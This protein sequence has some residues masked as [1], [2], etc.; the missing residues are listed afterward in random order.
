MIKPSV[1]GK[2]RSG[3]FAWRGVLRA[4]LLVMGMGM[5]ASVASAVELHGHRGARGLLPENTLASFREA[6]R[7]GVDC[8]E[9][10]VG[11]SRDGQVVIHHDRFLSPV[12]ARR[13]GKW[14]DAP[15]TLRTLS[16][17]ELKQFDVGRIKPGT[18]YAARFAD[19]RPIDGSQIPLLKELLAMP[20]LASHPN[21]CL[22]IE[23]K[24]SPDAPDDTFAPERISQALVEVLDGFK[25]R[26]RARV[27]SFDWRNLRAIAKLAPDL[28]LSFLTAEQ[29]WQDNIQ[30]GKPGASPWLAGIDIDD[31]G[32]SV[33]RA[34]AHFGGRFWSPYFRDLTADALK[35]AHG[36]G[37]KVIVWTV[38]E[39]QD[40]RA[41][42]ELGVDG[43]ITDYP[44][45][46][47]RILEAWNRA[48]TKTRGQ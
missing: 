22:N 40:I 11:L 37:L 3:R 24:T 12:L 41:L 35:E 48:R 34:V 23:I 39:E 7:Q 8:I 21:V 17:A 2:G 26:A 43:V 18:R 36:L 15:V 25:F 42:L 46:G 14:I 1:Q 4:G 16:A 30:R 10:D 33:P 45:R 6:I 29:R 47:H 32:G 38:N 9:T 13:A 20:E 19:Q 44:D 31:F 27:Q 28:T 5:A